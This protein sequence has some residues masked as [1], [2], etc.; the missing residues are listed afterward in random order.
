MLHAQSHPDEQPNI[1]WWGPERPELGQDMKAPRKKT[2][3]P[4]EVELEGGF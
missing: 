2:R 3:P 4:A 1:D